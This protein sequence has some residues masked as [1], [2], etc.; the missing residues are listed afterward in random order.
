LHQQLEVQVLFLLE[1]VI[2]VGQVVVL[3]EVLLVVLLQLIKVLLVVMEEILQALIVLVGEVLQQLELI[4][5]HRLLVLV[6]MV[7]QYQ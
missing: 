4:L 5:P 6:E 7:Y 1:T 2:L 3:V